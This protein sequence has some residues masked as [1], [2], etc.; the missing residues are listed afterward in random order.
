M[1]L[2][3]ILICKLASKE[4]NKNNRKLWL[5]FHLFWIIET[6]NPQCIMTPEVTLNSFTFAG[7]SFIL[8]DDI[9]YCRMKFHIRILIPCYFVYLFIT[10]TQAGLKGFWSDH[11]FSSLSRIIVSIPCIPVD[12]ISIWWVRAMVVNTI[13]I[14]GVAAFIPPGSF[15]HHGTAGT[16]RTVIILVFG[17]K[18]VTAVPRK[19]IA[20]SSLKEITEKK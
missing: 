8:Q 17:W 13:Q 9:S 18:G 12:T 1:G 16:G 2:R 15:I 11:H 4:G 10:K 3:Q 19:G 20:S 5:M 6:V 14:G 7:W